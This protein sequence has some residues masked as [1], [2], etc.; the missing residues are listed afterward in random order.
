MDLA[1]SALTGDLASRFI[2]F[3]MNNCSDRL[4]S[5]EKV[6]RLQ[7]L[8]LRVHMVIEE[9]E[10]RYI[11]N[12]SMLIQLKTLSA[13]MYQ[14]YHVLDNI[15]YRQH[16]KSSKELV[17]D[18]F[19]LSAYIPF[20]RSRTT[21]GVSSANKPINSELQ[22]TL[23][24]LE[25]AVGNMVEFVVLLGG[26]ERISRRPYDAYLRVDSFMFGRHVE[27]QQIISFLLL[28]DVNNGPPAVLPITGGRGVG[29]K[30]LVAHV[31][32]DGRVR[33]HFA[34]IL[35]LNGDGLSRITDHE[36]LPGR[37]LVAVEFVSDVDG[38]DW[39]EFYSSVTSLGRGSKVIIFGRDE[40]LKKFGNVKPISVN[41]LPF[42]EY[43]YLFK[44]LA[45]GSSDPVDHPRLA[46]IVEEFAKVLGGSLVSANFIAHSMRKN[47]DAQFWLCKLNRV[48]MTVKLNM[49]RFGVHPS[50]LLDR[51][52]PVHLNN[53]HYL[54]SPGA[55]SCPTPSA[56]SPSN[57]SGKNLPKV[58]FGEEAGHI[59]P[60]KGDFELISWRSR[61]PPHT[62]FVHLVQYVPS[63]V[64]DKPETSLSGK[65]RPDLST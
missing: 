30:T 21:T 35:H 19:P 36:R 63:C 42:E 14:G 18:S 56:S 9:A 37:T 11:S 6:E 12:S 39:T 10:G 40:K 4:C 20:K 64:D 1:I 15:R 28:H 23:Q 2:S 48:R 5:E 53:G 62:L 27:K 26:C 13:A 65:K 17:S 34:S 46:A 22:S 57:V 59:V 47:P 25:A 31:C 38:D 3:L 24:N 16:K 50:D 33:S 52:R 32:D 7:Q 29:K 61:L 51:G 49:S 41:C 44:I 60:P 58:I 45:F 43:R 8:L 54:L 55:P